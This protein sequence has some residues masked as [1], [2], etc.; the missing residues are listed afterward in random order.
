MAHFPL[1]HT[2]LERE[3]EQEREIERG[4]QGC[5]QFKKTLPTPHWQYKKRKTTNLS[6]L[7]FLRQPWLKRDDS[8]HAAPLPHCFDLDLFLWVFAASEKLF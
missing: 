4:F 8:E 2:D 3:R 6:P 7:H 1:F 5:G